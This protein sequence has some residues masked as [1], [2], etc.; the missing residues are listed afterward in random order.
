MYRNIICWLARPVILLL[1]SALAFSCKS[2]FTPK[3]RGYL[4]IDFPEKKYRK[5]DSICPFVFEYPVY[6]KIIPYTRDGGEPC[7]MDIFFPAYDGNIH[8]SYKRIH[9]N[10]SEY[11]EDSRTLAYKHTIRADAIREKVFSKPAG[12]VY[13]LLYDIKGNAASN[14]QFYLTDSTDHFLRGSLY[15]NVTPDADSLAPVID[16]LQKDVLHL[17]ETFQWKDQRK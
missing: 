11:T 4:R 1:I 9:D 12:E 16:F 5:F 15:L 13:G 3:P 7:W 8:I 10:L 17:M 14:M 6:A 2:K